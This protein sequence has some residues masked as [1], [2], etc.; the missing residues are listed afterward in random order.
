MNKPDKVLHI[1]VSS[2][3]DFMACRR[4][5][6][7]KRIK[8]YEKIVFNLAMFVGKVVHV[9]IAALLEKGKDPIKT[10]ME[11]YR[12]EKKEVNNKMVLSTND[13]ED[14]AKQEF[15]VKGMVLA[16]KK[17]YQKLLKDSQHLQSEVEGALQLSDNVVFVIKLDNLMN[18]RGIKTLHELKTSKY[19]T[20]D[21]IRMIQTNRQTTI[22]YRAYNIIYPKKPIKAILYD[23]IRK[24]SIRQKKNE[25]KIAYAERLKDWYDAPDDMSKFHMERFSEPIVSEEEIINTII[26]VS[27]EMIRSRDKEDYYANHEQCASYYG[28]ICPYYTLCHEGGETRENLLLYQIRKPYH[29][30]KSNKKGKH[31]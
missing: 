7:Y 9:G 1:S 5:Y 4:L 24:P 26:K 31:A 18:V 23:I 13:L 28:D 3:N 22:Y 21:Y 12:E 30:D 6:Y 25:T 14:V 17:R 20:P 8:K 16:Y 29:V 19:I 15:I 10:T 11:Y 27:E 2:L